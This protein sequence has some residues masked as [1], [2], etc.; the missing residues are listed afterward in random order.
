MRT[1]RQAIAATTSMLNAKSGGTIVVMASALLTAFCAL[2][3]F[4]RATTPWSTLPDAD[5]WGN[6]GNIITKSGLK[7]DL[8]EL[9]RHN[10]EHIVPIPKLI[11]AANY[12][13]TSGS[14]TGLIIYSLAVGAACALLLL[15]LAR[16]ILADTPWRYALCAILFPLAIF[17]AKLTHSYFLGMSGAI[18]LTADLFVIVSAALLASA[19]A[20]ARSSHL[21]ASLAA[22]LLGVLA[23]STAVYMLLVILVYCLA[24]LVRP[25]LPGPK[26]PWLFGGCIAAIAAV[27]VFGLMHRNQ[28]RSHPPFDF[29]PVGLVEFVLIY[30]GNAFTTGPARIFA[31][32]ALLAAGGFAMHKLLADGRGNHAFLWIV[33]FFYAPFNALMTGVGRLGYG[34]KIAATSRYQ[35]VVVIS[36]IAAV[37]LILAALP[38]GVLPRR[39]AILRAIAMGLLVF[40]G[41]LFATN[42]AY[43][44]NYSARNEAK[45]VAEIALRLGIEGG[46][47]LRASTQAPNQLD[48]LLPTLRAARHAP[49]HWQSA[50]EAMLG[51]KIDDSPGKSA[52]RLESASHYKRAHNAGEAIE[53]AGFAQRDGEAPDCIVIID[54]DRT[55]IGAGVL[56]SNRPDIEVETRQ[57]LGRIGW[58]GVAKQT[59]A[60]PICALA[61][62]P[63]ETALT[64]LE[65]CRQELAPGHAEFP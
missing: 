56:V 61:L 62:F 6:V 50:C 26:S 58:K 3:T 7:L 22:A 35:S 43:V 4:R 53:L 55:V 60:F 8:A 29:D 25:S 28:P 64:P 15:N 45:A 54:G 38:K 52:G 21:A 18:W 16:P 41:V 14:N 24:K 11:Y 19:I 9:F 48:R 10:N 36:V 63:G 17:S 65:G 27:M 34:V 40:C 44:P 39:A 33:L 46:R 42:R 32:V 47:H 49:F 12:L 57:A 23:Y 13:A 51:R 31:G 1:L 59:D 5:Y 37:V 20:T 30:L 2:I